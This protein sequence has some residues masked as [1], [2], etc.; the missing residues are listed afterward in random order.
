MVVIE[1]LRGS[2]TLFRSESVI[3]DYKGRK[4]LPYLCYFSEISVQV[5]SCGVLVVM[6]T[7]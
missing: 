1:E 4:N 3:G 5:I 6:T 2:W 7:T